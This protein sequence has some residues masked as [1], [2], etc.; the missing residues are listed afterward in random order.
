MSTPLVTVACPLY[1]SAPHVETIA[2]NI[3][4]ITYAPVEVLISDRHLLDDAIDRLAE[5]YR[6]DARVRIIRDPDGA[7]W[8]AHYNALVRAARG[9]YFCWMPHDDEYAPGY[10]ESL[11]AGLDAAPDAILAFG[12]ME[13]ESRGRP[14]IMPPFTPA[15]TRPDEPPSPGLSLRLHYHWDLSYA[16]RG[17]FR[18]ERMLAADLT[19]PRT[20]QLIFADVC[21]LFAMSLHGRFVFVPDARC[22]KVH[23]PSGASAAWTFGVRQAIDEWRT[24]RAAIARAP[25]P[26]RDRIAATAALSY[27]MAIRVAWRT[28]RLVIGQ[29]NRRAPRTLRRS[30]LA[31]TKHVLRPPF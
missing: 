9:T 13:S 28:M 7:D 3:D 1:R 23:Y 17:L 10:I 18:R 11:A 31:P 12:V 19:L 22:R 21:W 27:V 26:R 6:D 24:M 20:D 4:R 16:M 30:V 5:R 8:V 15:P 25:A 2:A 14:V 29:S